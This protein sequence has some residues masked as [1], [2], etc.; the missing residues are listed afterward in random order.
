[1]GSRHNCEEDNAVGTDLADVMR[2][3]VEDA[4]VAGA[5]GFGPTRGCL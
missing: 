3:A 5:Q 4:E 1:M 2:I